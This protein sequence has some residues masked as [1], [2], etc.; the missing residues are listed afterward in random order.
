M[1]RWIKKLFRSMIVAREKEV[2]RRI[3][4]IA[5]YSVDRADLDRKMRDAGY[6]GL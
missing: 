5:K 4:Y 3:G 6:G 1:V 2:Q